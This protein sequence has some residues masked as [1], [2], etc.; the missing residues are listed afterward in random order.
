M[1]IEKLIEKNLKFPAC[2]QADRF[3][4]GYIYIHIYSRMLKKFKQMNKCMFE[5]NDI[6]DIKDFNLEIKCN[7]IELE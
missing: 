3:R 7:P 2:F 4:Y 6:I 5:K 1:Y